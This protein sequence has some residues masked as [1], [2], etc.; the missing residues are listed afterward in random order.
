MWYYGRKISKNEQKST[1]LKKKKETI[2]EEVQD[3]ETYKVAKEILEK[4]A[5]EQLRRSP[6]SCRLIT[7]A[8][9]GWLTINPVSV[10]LVKFES[11]SRSGCLFGVLGPTAPR[12]T[13]CGFVGLSSI[14]AQSRS[15]PPP[16]GVSVTVVHID[17]Q[18]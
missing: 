18:L 6:V 7:A 8:G 1:S 4:F 14:A 3:K 15:P 16:S 11:K 13:L 12:S 2:L 5:P 10:T 17:F 9:T